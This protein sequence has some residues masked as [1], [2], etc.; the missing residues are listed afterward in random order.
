MDFGPPELIIVVVLIL[1]LFGGS[2]LPK[3]AKNLGKAQA[4]FKQALTPKDEPASTATAPVAATVAAMPTDSTDNATSDF[5]VT[6]NVTDDVT[7][8]V[9]DDVTDNVTDD[10]TDYVTDDVPSDFETMVADKA[11]NA[12][13]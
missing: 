3:L 9:T 6:D 11:S 10:V 7:D 4:E 1:V 2:Q 13:G 8:N 12:G 5:D